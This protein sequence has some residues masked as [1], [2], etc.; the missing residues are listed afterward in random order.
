MSEP[1]IGEIR[2]FG[3][4]FAPVG[5]ALCDGSLL[6]IAEYDALYNLLGT[7]YGGDGQQTFA[8][9]DLRGRMPVH[10]G[11]GP[12]L[13]DRVAGQAFGTETVT[14]TVAQ[15]PPHDHRLAASS[16]LA[17]SSSPV[18]AV[19]AQVLEDAAYSTGGAGVGLQADA[20]SPA[21]SGL[22][23]ANVQPVLAV[24]YIISLFGIYPFAS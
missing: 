2:L 16:G 5:W 4:N 23:H 9:P 14:L 13:S 10:R 8:V 17:T 19:P 6:P 1:H 20:V 24:T 12:G 3:G 18:G 11:Q 22:P 21:G 7:R 15:L